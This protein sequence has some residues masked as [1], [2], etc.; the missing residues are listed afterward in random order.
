MW[1]PTGYANES[2][3]TFPVRT[4][5][6]ILEKMGTRSRSVIFICSILGGIITYETILACFQRKITAKSDSLDPVLM[7][8]LTEQNSSAEP[9]SF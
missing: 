6:D 1:V 7:I 8:S 3:F 9:E 2:F 4:T 5:G